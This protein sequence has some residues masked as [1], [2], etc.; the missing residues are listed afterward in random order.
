MI[1]DPNET[2]ESCADPNP[3][4]EVCHDIRNTKVYNYNLIPGDSGGPIYQVATSTTRYA[5]GTHV[6]SVEGN[7]VP[8]IGQDGWYTPYGS[9][10]TAYV[11][12]S[13]GD[14]YSICVTA[15]C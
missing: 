4:A 14:N 10:Q 8:V 11:L 15:A 6:H 13:P 9:G 5:M 1:T 12:A 7:T 2:K 3:G